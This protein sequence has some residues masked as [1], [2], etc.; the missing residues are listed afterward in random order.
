MNHKSK[1]H[2]NSIPKSPE[3]KKTKRIIYLLI[4]FL[5][6]VI[7]LVLLEVSLRIFNYGV[8]TTLF[9]SIPD[10]SSS[11][12]GINLNVARRYF[13]QLSDVPTPR[14]DLFLKVKPKN[15]YRIFVLGGSTTAGYPYGNSVTFTRI[16]NRRLSDTFPDKRIEVVNTAM[17]AINTYTQLDFMDEILEQKPDAI[18]IYSGHNEYYGA[19]GVGSMESFGKSHW[20][21]KTILKLQKFK[22][23]LL[24]R[25]LVSTIKSWFSESVP[26]NVESKTA[27]LMERIVK[28]K[29]IPLD[30][31]IYQAGKNQFRKNIEEI[32]EMA[33]DAGVKVIISELVSNIEGNKPFES[34][35]SN[36]LPS[37]DEEYK[38]ALESLKQ[39]NYGEAKNEFYFAKDLDALRFR[40]PEE[41]NKIIH[42][43]A[44][45][46]KIPVVPMEKYFEERSPHGIIGDNLM[47]DHL[48]PNID[49]YFLMADAFYNT[50]RDA[51]LISTNWEQKNTKPSA[52]YRNNWGYT[53]L[54]SM[55]AYLSVL[56]L[57]GGWPFIKTDEPNFALSNY[58]PINKIDSVAAAILLTRE[59]T[60]EQGHIELANYY[61]RKGKPEL[62]FKEFN[63]LIY[64]VP[65][66][67]LFY[68]PA[69]KILTKL[70]DYNHAL[71][72]LFQLL[73]YQKSAFAYQ[74]I[75]QIYLINNETIKGITFLEKA[76]KTGSQ[77]M[78]LLYNL[79]RAYY[80]ISQFA[81][82]DSIITRLKEK[83]ADKTLIS[84]LEL[85]RKTSYENFGIALSYL[86]KTRALMESKEYD[87]A[88]GLIQ[89]SLSVRETPEAYELSGIIKLV[90]NKKSEALLNF[91]KA[92]A[93]S[94]KISQGLLY[95][96][97]YAYYIN[98]DFNKAKYTFDKLNKF[99]PTFK[100]PANLKGKLSKIQ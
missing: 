95:N 62:E 56:Q 89:K 50:M 83:S 42:E 76:I 72:L 19:L 34:V 35:K 43:V 60:L 91:E 92:D 59:L 74:W 4:T 27:T 2:K 57:K 24:M 12:Y 90:Q 9:I 7:I 16:L 29:Y 84:N 21:V 87:K 45:E 85:F 3:I 63:A 15:T 100:D 47:L 58:I 64:T 10:S 77:D 41:F 82:G 38:K 22:I 32:I 23:Y 71:Q 98:S 61:D 86:K 79:G 20:I 99:Y 17:T 13:I 55:Y 25:D 48:H 26:G 44:E 53:P 31:D 51:K 37:A 75:G 66:L 80:N 67:D 68:E 54:D 36:S 94:Y 11:Y 8:D 97:T 6:P 88:N 93:L 46:N 40:A 65:Y 70:G 73:Y 1:I 30:G 28:D 69:I 5:I 81:E 33:K 78:L 14:K 49:G 39:G 96:L 18:L 52:Y